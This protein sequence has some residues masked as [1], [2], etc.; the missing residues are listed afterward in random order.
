MSTSSIKNGTMS[1]GPD[2]TNDRAP[3]N[4]AGGVPSYMTPLKREPWHSGNNSEGRPPAARSGMR[5]L[6]APAA[7][8]PVRQRARRARF[9]EALRGCHRQQQQHGGRARRR[10][11]RPAAQPVPGARPPPQPPGEPHEQASPQRARASPKG[12]RA[13]AAALPRRPSW[14]AVSAGPPAPEEGSQP[15]IVSE[16]GVRARHA[17]LPELVLVPRAAG[18]R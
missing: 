5:A 16:P 15:A 12:R 14:A 6:P 8:G 2:C 10:R 7:P 18:G 1:V 9:E 17:G 3:K 13:R 11:H 4:V